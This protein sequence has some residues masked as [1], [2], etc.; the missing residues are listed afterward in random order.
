MLKRQGWSATSTSTMSSAIAKKPGSDSEKIIK[1]FPAEGLSSGHNTATALQE[2]AA[3]K[4]AFAQAYPFG[5]IVKP[6]QKPN[7]APGIGVIEAGVSEVQWDLPF[8]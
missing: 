7:H 4:A 2:C 5:S 1:A 8:F 3:S 6:P